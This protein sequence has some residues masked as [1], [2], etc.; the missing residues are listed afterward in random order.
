VTALTLRVN[1]EL[2]VGERGDLT[3]LP[4]A[5]FINMLSL[6]LKLA[7]DCERLDAQALPH[8]DA[9]LAAVESFDRDRSP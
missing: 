3:W 9:Y 5:D 2:S 8:L 7:E 6:S 4:V 1:R